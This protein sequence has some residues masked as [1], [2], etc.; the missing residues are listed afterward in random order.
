MYHTIVSR[1]TRTLLQFI[2]IR[3]TLIFELVKIE[4]FYIIHDYYH[5]TYERTMVV[6]LKDTF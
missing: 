4:F 5:C 1:T 2:G 3:L 6:M